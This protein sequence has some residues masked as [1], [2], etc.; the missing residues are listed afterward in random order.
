MVPGSTRSLFSIFTFQK[1]QFNIFNTFFKSLSEPW[2][3][4][5]VSL[6]GSAIVIQLCIVTV[7]FSSTMSLTLFQSKYSAHSYPEKLRHTNH[8]QNK[9]ENFKLL[10]PY[11]SLSVK[12]KHDKRKAHLWSH[13]KPFSQ[14]YLS[15]ISNLKIIH[16]HFKRG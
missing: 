15:K 13:E 12:S 2:L 7:H 8:K 11:Q 16:T 1:S 3:K 14:K 9:L 10:H 6:V 5:S 4:I